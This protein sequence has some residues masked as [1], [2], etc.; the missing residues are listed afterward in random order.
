MWTILLVGIFGFLLG[1]MFGRPRL[2]AS[3][4]G[5][6]STPC[7]AR[8]TCGG[9]NCNRTDAQHQ[10]CDRTQCVAGCVGSCTLK[11]GHAAPHRCS[12][13]HNF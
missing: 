3:A 5:D 13:N 6:D 9:T 11:N 1:T 10:H 2:L 4:W 12:H 8:C 7:P